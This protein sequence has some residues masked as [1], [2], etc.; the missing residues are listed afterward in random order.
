[1]QQGNIQS[2][3]SSLE[4]TKSYILNVLALSSV[5]HSWFKENWE[6][7]CLKWKCIFYKSYFTLWVLCLIQKMNTK[8]LRFVTRKWSEN[9]IFFE[10]EILELFIIIL[11]LLKTCTILILRSLMSP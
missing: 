10:M 5:L 11:L 6:N 4:G 8:F 1:M 7:V 3:L 9:I 2:A